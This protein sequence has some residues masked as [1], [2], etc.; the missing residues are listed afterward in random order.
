MK[1]FILFVFVVCS[2]RLFAAT[3]HRPTDAQIEAMAR[4]NAMQAM[5]DA[6]LLRPSTVAPKP[7]FEYD[8]TAY[9]VFSDDDFSG[10][11]SDMKRIIAQNLP[12]D[13]TLVIYT[14]ST[15]KTHQQ[16]LLNTYGSYISRDRLK[17]VQVP[18]SGANDFWSRDNMPIPVMDT[19]RMALVDA[20]YYYNFEPDA[21]FGRMFSANVDRHNYFY[22][23]GNFAVNGLGDCIVVNR[24]ASYPGGVSDTAAIPDTI[25]RD[26]YGCKT[27]TRLQH[28]KGIGHAD[29]VVKFMSD[30]VVVTDTEAYASILRNKG[31]TVV[32]LPEPQVEYETYVNA[33][34]VND[35]LFVPTFGETGDQEAINTYKSVNPALKIVTIPTQELATQ[36]QGG[37]HC[38]TMNYPPA[39]L[40]AIRYL[41]QS[42]H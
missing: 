8:H 22:E 10:I 16:Q 27:L 32:M 3:P 12:S 4:A 13:V 7:F 29:E 28:L 35:V 14:Q 15:S 41:L 34:Q 37:I 6:R 25:F 17:V 42:S 5:I 11:A 26:K 19:N 24:K 30:S 20:K 23:G 36:G 18:R 40:N 38:I 39:P 33:L 31:F 21:Y 9:V 1:K 2:S